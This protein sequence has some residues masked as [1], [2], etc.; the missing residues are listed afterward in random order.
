VPKSF[1]RENKTLFVAKLE[2]RK[3][4][5]EKKLEKR[6]REKEKKEEKEEKPITNKKSQK[7][8]F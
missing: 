2:K 1:C 5:K 8:F 7:L 3:R 6:K 4:E